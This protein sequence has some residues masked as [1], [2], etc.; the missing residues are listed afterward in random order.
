MIAHVV[1][2]YCYQYELKSIVLK[3]IVVTKTV[4]NYSAEKNR[5]SISLWNR[6]KN[7]PSCNLHGYSEWLLV[8]KLRQ[9]T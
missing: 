3:A 7:V 6:Y 4:I 5:L 1:M 9:I 8:E 2:K